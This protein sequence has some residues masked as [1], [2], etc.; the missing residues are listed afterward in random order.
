MKE[1]AAELEEIWVGG[2][3]LVHQINDHIGGFLLIKH[4]PRCGRPLH[5]YRRVCER[6]R[7][8]IDR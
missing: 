6:E 5:M 2:V 7:R 1:L 4:T 3:N 8:K